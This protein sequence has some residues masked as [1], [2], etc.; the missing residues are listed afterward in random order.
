MS[1]SKSPQV[2]L[3]FQWQTP[4]SKECYVAICE[5]VELGYNTNDAILAALPQFSV[6]RLVL[7]LDK[8]LAAGMAHLNMSTLSIDTDM[9]IVEALAAGQAL[10]LPLEA[11]QLQRNDPLLCKILQGIGVQNPSGAL[12]LLRPKVEVI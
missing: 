4:H 2:R 10:E 3:S 12:S 8:L 1:A 7:G 9:R 6:N 5:A 11:E